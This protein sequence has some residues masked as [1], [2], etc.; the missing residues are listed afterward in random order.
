MP[1]EQGIETED[2]VP[3]YDA[4]VRAAVAPMHAEAQIT[5]PQLSQQLAGHLVAVLEA[6]G[7]WVRARGMDGYTGWMH[8][9]FLAR[10]PPPSARQSRHPPLMSLGC[11][12]EDPEGARRALPLRALLS[13]GERVIEGETISSGELPGRFP[14]TGEAVA[15]TVRKYFTGTSYLWGG[16]TPWGA[17][18]S[19]MVQAVYALHGVRLP[20]DAKEQAEQGVTVENPLTGA[21]PGDLWF[22]SS[23]A[24][25]RATHVGI[26]LGPNQMVHQALARGGYAI[27]QLD[28]VRDPYVATL[29]EQFLVAK[30]VI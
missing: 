6:Q 14:S 5:S 2:A 15:S 4:R 27:E 30:G 24:D 29:R 25:R 12:T 3:L 13:P 10:V 23:Q 28:D 8:S 20:R 26:A 16:V 1:A 7:D 11:T 19:G 9:G 17:D 22:F 18:C 21:N